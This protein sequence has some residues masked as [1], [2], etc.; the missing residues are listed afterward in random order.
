MM[1]SKEDY[2]IRTMAYYQAK[3]GVYSDIVTVLT[4]MNRERLLSFR[5]INYLND[6][7]YDFENGEFCEIRKIGKIHWQIIRLIQLCLFLSVGSET[8]QIKSVSEDCKTYQYYSYFKSF[9]EKYTIYP[10]V[11]QQA[12][13]CYTTAT[14]SE[15]FKKKISEMES[16]L[17]RQQ[18]EIQLLRTQN[19]NLAQQVE[20]QARIIASLRQ[21]KVSRLD[22]ALSLEYVLSYI[23]TR[24]QYSLCDQLFGLLKGDLARLATDEEYEA[25]KQVEQEMLDASVPQQHIDRIENHNDIQN[26]NV[27]PGMV[28]SPSFPIGTAPTELLK[29]FFELIKSQDNGQQV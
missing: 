26:S 28:N 9:I 17:K 12:A 5:I 6:A 27:F 2:S 23:R 11:S 14:A 15:H 8:P 7:C 13:P 10:T 20:E 18:D 21:D 1:K 19:Q 16:V 4:R 22:K 29:Q 25:I 3:G 24:R